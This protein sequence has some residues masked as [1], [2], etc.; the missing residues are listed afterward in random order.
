MGA[1][2]DF[3]RSI[4]D[5][6]TFGTGMQLV[7]RQRGR[8]LA[9]E[10]VGLARPGSPMTRRSIQCV[11]CMTK[12]VVASA[13][14]ATAD[15]VGVSL[16]GDLRDISS[17]L[18]TLLGDR[19]ISLQDVL[20][21]RAGLHLVTAPEAMF[22]PG[23]QRM[24]AVGRATFPDEWRI[25]VDRSYS[26]YQGWNVL[27]VWLEE[28]TGLPFGVAM[29]T[30]TLAPLGLDDCYFGVA[31]EQWHD[32][33][34][35]LGTNFQ[36]DNGTLL[37]LLH[38]LLRRFVDDP[39]MHVI[40]GQASAEAMAGFYEAVLDVLAGRPRQGLPGP[41]RMREM[42]EP[43]GERASDRVCT[44]PVSF[45]LGFMG[46]LVEAFGESIG[47]RAFGHLGLMGNAFAFADPDRDLVAVFVANAVYFSPEGK[48]GISKMRCSLVEAI[49]ADAAVA[50]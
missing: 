23:P 11:Y 25:G 45:G 6:G 44:A 27:R 46:D 20:S 35:R 33:R 24:E 1:A 16:D 19:R 4:V 32:V 41:A 29:R 2:R 14:C 22:L 21:H 5:Q 36:L 43:N 50:A 49:Y 18:A 17:R 40:G 26:D 31:D 13:V 8:T 30:K 9:N 37:P 38:Q 42:V 48:Q 28:V 3:A 15:S 47:T 12:P 34:D 7:V 39:L 10:S